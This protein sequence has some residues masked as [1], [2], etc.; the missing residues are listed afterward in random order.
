MIR[1]FSRI[2]RACLLRAELYEEVEADHA[3]TYQ[4]GAVV[5]LSS[6]ASGLGGSRNLQ[7]LI[8]S[9]AAF[10]LGWVFWAFLT[11]WIG[12]RLLPEPQTESNPGELLRTLGFASAPGILRLLGLI[13]GVG[14]VVFWLTSVWMLT[15]MVVAV[16]QALDYTSTLRAVIVCAIGWL[17][18][19]AVIWLSTIQA[20]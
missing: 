5:V 14:E 11:S 16:R 6:V 12:T 7:T 15:A 13:P 9:I 1:F 3:A 20:S 19:F 18:H 2:L 10:L 17:L 4:A 8:L